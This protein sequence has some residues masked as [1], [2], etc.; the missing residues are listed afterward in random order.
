MSDVREARMEEGPGGL[1]P[2]DDGWF[3]VNARDARWVHHDELGSAVVFESH[4][5]RFPHYGVNIQVLQPGQPNCMYHGEEAQE[6]FLVLWGECLALIEG[7]ERRLRQWDLVH[8][9]PWTEHV[10]VGA[11]DGP[12]GILMIGA[13]NTGEGL[14]YP[15]NDLALRHNAGVEQETP[16]GDVAY[17]RFSPVVE[18]PYRGDLPEM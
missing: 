7:Q 17:A 2:A 4:D 1:A 16:D 3:V 11:G 14:I 5:H 13:R 9:P 18:G 10:F 15:A 12:C 6:D 8:C